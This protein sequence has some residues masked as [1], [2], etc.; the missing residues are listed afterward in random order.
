MN[1]MAA[2]LVDTVLP[3]V[4]IRQWVCSFSWEL[5]YVMG[6][7]KALT[8]DIV[9]C[10]MRTV[11]ES[12]K[13]RA[14]RLLNL[15]SVDACETGAV[16]VVQRFD[17][18][19]RLNVHGHSLV[20]DGVYVKRTNDAAAE[21]TEPEFYALPEPTEQDVQWVADTAWRRIEK[22]LKKHGRLP[23]D[24]SGYDALGD[25]QPVLGHCYAQSTHGNRPG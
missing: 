6:Y 12:I 11:I 18:A 5:R 10:F 23:D 9:S 19:L 15:A 21:N 2:H 17:S 24:D 20:L 1:A 13:R 8:S 4:P 16:L 22:V 3:K 14:K 7:D 25:E